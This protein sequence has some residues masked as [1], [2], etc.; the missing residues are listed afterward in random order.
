M[1]AGQDGIGPG[2][3]PEGHRRHV[4][5]STTV[6]WVL[7]ICRRVRRERFDAGAR[8]ARSARGP[9][10]VA[11]G[12]RGGTGQGPGLHQSLHPTSTPTALAVG[13]DDVTWRGTSQ[14]KQT[15][16][17]S[18]TTSLE[19]YHRTEGGIARMHA[20]FTS[21]RKDPLSVSAPPHAWGMNDARASALAPFIGQVATGQDG[22][23][24][25]RR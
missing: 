11:G 2:S 17:R 7:A 1:A 4:G 13:A 15:Y 25:G 20:I 6:A 16:Q 5:S 23:G 9:A 3:E 19:P 24:P 8:H 18:A 21:P 22:I 12:P 14:P 10:C